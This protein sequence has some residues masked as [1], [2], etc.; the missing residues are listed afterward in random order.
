VRAGKVRWVLADRA[1]GGFAR[2]GRTGSSTVMAAVAQTCRP[3]S[4]S[5]TS[6]SGLYDCLGRA[7]ALAAA[8]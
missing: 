1:G 6:A 7:D 5:S 8:S 4:T 3:V 2:D